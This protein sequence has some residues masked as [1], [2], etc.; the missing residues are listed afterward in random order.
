MAQVPAGPAQKL[1][2]DQQNVNS[3]PLLQSA[4]QIANQLEKQIPVKVVLADDNQNVPTFVQL[5]NEVAKDLDDLITNSQYYYNRPNVPFNQ[6]ASAPI[7]SPVPVP[8]S[9]PL[10]SQAAPLIAAP[11]IVPSASVASDALPEQ[12]SRQSDLGINWALGVDPFG[13][14]GATVSIGQDP[15]HHH[16]HQYPVPVCTT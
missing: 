5:S 4:N 2:E 1:D 7:A 3:Q 8:Y 11:L 10:V 16:H 9:A 13:R 12:N 14:P 6:P 15:H